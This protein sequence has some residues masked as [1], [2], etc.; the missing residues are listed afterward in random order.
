MRM[1]GEGMEEKKRIKE[2]GKGERGFKR[3]EIKKEGEEGQF[4]ASRAYQECVNIKYMFMSYCRHE[5][6]IKYC[7]STLKFTLQ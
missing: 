5:E 7:Q 6:Y 2:G 1:R 3:V 4:R